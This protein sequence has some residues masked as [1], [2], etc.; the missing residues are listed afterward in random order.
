MPDDGN[1]MRVVGATDDEDGDGLTHTE[2][3]A[4]G[5]DPFDAD[6]DGDGIPDGIEVTFGSDLLE[7]DSQ[8]V[9]VTVDTDP[10]LV[11]GYARIEIRLT[12][13]SATSLSQVRVLLPV[14]EGLGFS[15]FEG[16]EPDASSQCRAGPTDR[17]C[18]PGEIAQWNLGNPR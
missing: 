7:A 11:G 4:L 13:S 8:P 1:T 15:Y 16:V 10:V 3:R 18:D 6:T 14:P 2:E 9:S 12:N 17:Y 5:S